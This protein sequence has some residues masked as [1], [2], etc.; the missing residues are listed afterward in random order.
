MAG[1]GFRPKLPPG[2]EVIRARVLERDGWRCRYTRCGDEAADAYPSADGSDG[3]ALCAGHYE[4]RAAS[5]AGKAGGEASRRQR[6]EIASRRTRQPG[7][8]PGLRQPG[9]E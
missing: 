6:H 5:E 2:W 7:A 3:I 9:G 1:E 4:S 8:H